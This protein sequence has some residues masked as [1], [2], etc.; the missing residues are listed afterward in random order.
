MGDGSGERRG[1]V[2]GDAVSRRRRLVL[3]ALTAAAALL[4]AGV[5]GLAMRGHSTPGAWSDCALEPAA[6]LGAGGTSV[7]ARLIGT[8]W[9]DS[10]APADGGLLRVEVSTGT[11]R[12]LAVAVSRG[13]GPR[14]AGTLLTADV[15]GRPRGAF[16]IRDASSWAYGAQGTTP[17]TDAVVIML[18]QGQRVCGVTTSPETA[19]LAGKHPS[20]TDQVILPAGQGWQ[21]LFATLPA[22]D[23]F[24]GATLQVCAGSA[25]VDAAVHPLESNLKPP[26]P[27]PAR[28][29]ALSC[30]NGTAYVDDGGRSPGPADRLSLEAHARTWASSSGLLSRYPDATRLSSDIS[31]YDNAIVRISDHEAVRAEVTYL[32]TAGIWAID[33]AYYC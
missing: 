17:G 31:G 7:G 30:P 21:A 33:V 4:V 22:L 24:E 13:D 9:L 26:L 10:G 20:L 19:E 32:R 1:R 3:V 2:V 23:D 18:P 27:A 14:A 16:W 5:G 15:A 12:G 6:G 11:C 29:S 8:P 28:T 25:V